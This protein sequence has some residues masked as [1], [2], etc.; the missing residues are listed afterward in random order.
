MQSSVRRENCA[1]RQIPVRICLARI[2]FACL[3][4]KRTHLARVI[5]KIHRKAATQRHGIFLADSGFKTIFL[6]RLESA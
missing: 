1:V 3:W 5:C 6:I 4:C 2:A